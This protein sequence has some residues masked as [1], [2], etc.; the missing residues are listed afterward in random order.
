[1]VDLARLLNVED[2]RTASRGRLP[3]MVFDFLDGGAESEATLRRN[4]EAFRHYDLVPRV[5]V[6]VG[7][8][9]T[10]VKLLGRRSPLP[11]IFSPTGA[12]RLFHPEG[13]I[14]V[15]RAAREAGIF[16]MLSTMATCS[17][18]QVA[19]VA[20]PRIFQL[21]VLRDRGLTR[22]LIER[23]VAAGYDALCLTVDMPVGGY[24]ER[25]VRNRLA[26]P[27]RPSVRGLL[28]MAARPRW[29]LGMLRG[30]AFRMANFD[31]VAG[32]TARH[33]NMAFVNSQFD[34]AL[35]WDDAAWFAA[36]SGL[37][38][39]IKGILSAADARRAVDIGA[40]A[41]MVSN[42]GGRQL[43]GAPATID[44]VTD[45][46]D[47]AGRDIE[48]VLDGGVRRGTD[49]LKALARGADACALGRP[50]LYALAAGGEAGVTRMIA[51]LR[52]ELERA[53]AL[54]GVADLSMAGSS[55]LRRNAP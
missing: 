12:T 52:A 26:L 17:V 4:C 2:F 39:M 36:Q 13:E 7:E 21:Y 34:R 28:G 37:P 45:I 15:A 47:A 1:M 16:Y 32:P 14:A 38:L 6:N 20:G 48:I 3:S 27:Y 22:A 31:E 18:E 19:E 50:Y 46:R 5:L 9:D 49:V 51:I 41:I 40:R 44:V 55:L 11:L 54:S 43:D 35:T 29:A 23:A 30:P 10:S 42:H 25:D 33:G 53:M 24:R 8:I